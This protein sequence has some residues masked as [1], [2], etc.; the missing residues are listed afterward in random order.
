MAKL[1][2][3]IR[4]GRVFNAY[5]KKFIK[6]DILVN[7]GRIFMV[8]DSTAFDFEYDRVLEVEG[9]TVIPGLIDIHMH[10]ESSMATPQAFSRELVRHG[11]TTIVSEPH[12]IANVFGIEGILEMIK[13]GAGAEIDIF[14]GIPSSVPSTSAEFETTG[15]AINLP[16]MAQLAANERV[17]CLGEVMNCYDL[18]HESEAKTNQIVR[19]FKENYPNLPIE[20]HCSKVGGEGLAKVLEAGVTS[21]HT[22]QTVTTLA[23][24]IAAG[25]F[26][27]LQEKS[28]N[29]ENINYI[30]A[31]HLTEHV[32]LVTD[33]VMADKLICQGHLNHLVR[34]AVEYGMPVEE[35]VYCATYTPARRMKLLDRGSIAPGKLADLIILDDLNEFCIGSVYKAGR[36]VFNATPTGSKTETVDH[37]FPARFLNSIKR[38]P[39][40]AGDLQ[41][42][43]EK[44]AVTVNCRIIKVQDGTTNTG[45]LIAP[46]AV[47]DGYLDWENSPYGLIA[48]FERY[49]KNNNI[50]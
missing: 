46:V 38:Q 50:G 31:N 32:A 9:K 18:I 36:E 12:E 25:M 13:A 7:A 21:D 33:D 29:P 30:V 26:I 1:D 37:Q 16:E 14:Y 8:G 40:T 48:V 2:L 19:F 44:T 45:E 20:G 4:G 39:I 10:I 22:Q 35:A 15:A 34:K 47:K 3:L 42:K 24:K 49:G 6:A 5:L 17:I 27:E 43:V 11:V 41:L 28:L 23:E